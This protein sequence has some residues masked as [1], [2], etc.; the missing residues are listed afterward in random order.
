MHVVTRE[1]FNDFALRAR[2]NRKQFSF[3]DSL[4]DRDEDGITYSYVFLII[5][6]T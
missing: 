3:F 5:F 4:I 6:T 2:K 1:Q